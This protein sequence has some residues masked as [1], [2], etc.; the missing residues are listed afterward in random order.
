MGYRLAKIILK[1]PKSVL[2]IIMLITIA[3]APFVARIPNDSSLEA[4]TLGNDP[5]KLYLDRFKVQFG[6]D[7]TIVIAF[8][9]EDIFT[10]SSLALIKRIT[11]RIESLENV[12]KVTSLTNVNNTVGT[13]EDFIV[14]HLIKD[15]NESEQ[16]VKRAKSEA[17]SNP[18]YV[19]NII[20]DDSKTTAILVKIADV[21]GN[22]AYK[23]TLITQ[24][25]DILSQEEQKTGQQF[26]TAGARL[27][28][29]YF[30]RFVDGDTK[31]FIPATLALISIISF[32]I[33]RKL[34]AVLI[35]LADVFICLIWTEGILYF[36]GATLNTVTAIIPPLIMALSVAVG[37]HV[38]TQYQ[39]RHKPELDK[40][41]VLL[42]TICHLWRPCFLAAFTTA[43]GFASLCVSQVPPIQ[44]FGIVAAIGMLFCF[45]V[46]MTF[47]PAT[48]ALIKKND[49]IEGTA[50]NKDF[51]DR[52]VCGIAR[53]TE[54]YPKAILIFSSL[55]M[56]V[57][58]LG[59]VRIIIDTNL[60][61]FFK[62]DSDVYTST[63]FIEQNIAGV[64]FLDISLESEDIDTFKDPEALKKIEQME[65]FLKNQTQVDNVLSINTCLKDMNKSFHNE[66]QAYYRIPDS[67][68]MIAQYLLL[69]SADDLEDYVDSDY[70]WTRVSA[71]VTEHSSKRLKGLIETIKIYL[72]D[73]FGG[74]IKARVTGTAVLESN[75]IQRIFDSQVQS[76]SMAMVIIFG[77][78][79]ILF[80]SVK[81]GLISIAP[82]IF[83]IIVNFGLM[84]WFGI[85]LDNATVMIS[86][87]AIGIA[88]DD[89]IHFVSQFAR[90]AEKKG[91]YNQHVC[92]TLESKGR[93]MISTS[94]VLFTGFAV[95]VLSSFVPTIYFGLLTAGI[96]VT[97]LIGDV[98][99]LPALLL[100]F[101]PDLRTMPKKS[102]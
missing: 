97:A 43:I 78:M 25:K 36:K 49:E 72:A 55:I 53:F 34:K 96:M 38:L 94:V 39:K 21:P 87:V 81:V 77:L 30:N 19:K 47:I 42:D 48:L 9:T 16:D 65:T 2:A 76:L 50:D 32:I 93:A 33:F 57:S 46:S 59:A 66:D 82:N 4:F 54:I 95:L 37:I 83:P 35:L 22:R 75:L 67:R 60:L 12:E 69:Y 13:N 62:K 24:I 61:D 86:A 51:L 29:Y 74:P 63:N 41:S 11:E 6:T 89:T 85:P 44:D 8:M 58:L 52:I 40:K 3:I 84:G 45:G 10:K 5:D 17:L 73:N 100:V 7:E 99:I 70:R 14:E 102:L 68:N 26:Y 64:T 15:I 23:D 56:I 20:S 88:V 1:Y 79:F 28:N 31:R 80:K 92:D 71:R 98:I 101:K 91:G 18:L 90:E 27:I